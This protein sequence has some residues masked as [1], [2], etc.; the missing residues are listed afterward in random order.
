MALPRRSGRGETPLEA[1]KRALAEEQMNLSRKMQMIEQ[2]LK[3]IPD[4]LREQERQRTERQALEKAERGRRLDPPVRRNAY[5][6]TGDTQPRSLRREQREAV[7]KLILLFCI[8]LGFIF[9]IY[10]LR[11]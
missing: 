1:Q 4:V 5:N 11:P 3:E 8:L 9:W 7:I 6:A 2:H 10:T